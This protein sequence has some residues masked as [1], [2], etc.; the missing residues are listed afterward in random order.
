MGMSRAALDEFRG[1]S[2][3]DLIGP[4][5]RLLI[6]GINPGLRSAAMQAHFSRRG[7]FYRALFQA[8]ITDR[9][10]DAFEGMTQEDSAYLVRRG[11]GIGS[12]VPGA[13]ARA[14]EL[15]SGQ[16]RAGAVSLTERVARCRPRVVAMLGTTA[17][18]VA[19]GAPKARVGR[20]SEDLSGAQLW[21]VP[22]PSGLNAHAS[23]ADLSA[24]YREVAVAAGLDVYDSHQ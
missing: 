13:T 1:V 22:N 16:L 6:V 8:G 19:F 14:D 4:G 3:P 2:L 12:L 9:V 24:A 15:T 21:V 20:Q 11:V 17:Y 18:R 23:L 5:L 7:R 10:I